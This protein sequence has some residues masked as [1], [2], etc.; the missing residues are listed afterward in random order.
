MVEVI[1]T[2]PC[3]RSV[4]AGVAGGQDRGGC[5]IRC[6]PSRHSRDAAPVGIEW[7]LDSFHRGSSDGNGECGAASLSQMAV[8]AECARY[9]DVPSGYTRAAV[10]HAGGIRSPTDRAS[11][12]PAARRPVRGVQSAA[13]ARDAQ[14]DLGPDRFEAQTDLDSQSA[15]EGRA[16]LRALAFEGSRE[17]AARAQKAQPEGQS[18]LPV[19]RASD[20]RLQHQSVSGRLSTSRDRRGQLAHLATHGRLLGRA[21][22][23]DATGTDGLGRLEGLSQ[24]AQVRTPGTGK[25]SVS[26]RKG[27][28]IQSC[29]TIEAES[30]MNNTGLYL[31]G[32]IWW[33]RIGRGVRRSSKSNDLNEARAQRDQALAVQR[34]FQVETDWRRHVEAQR[35]DSNSWIRRTH[36]HMRRKTKIRE[37]LPCI[38]LEEFTGVVLRSNG[39]CA[40]TGLPFHRAAGKHPFAI[41]IDRIDSSIGYCGGNLRVVLLAVNLGMSHWG[42]ES[43]RAIARAL[44]GKE[45]LSGCTKS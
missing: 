39:F 33:Y 31:R 6:G 27:C 34:P 23:R 43:F 26:C 45:L 1:L 15:P 4:R 14:T 5:G 22:R 7:R 18:R 8:P 40:L 12:S 24:R 36:S 30:C 35:E 9:P 20:R 13:H 41:S 16:H 10:A 37:W 38:T 25:F 21:E 3:A 42:E 19:E 28:T 11:L 29:K 17:G 44:V 32:D 2:T